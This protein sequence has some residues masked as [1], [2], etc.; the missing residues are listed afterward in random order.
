MKIKNK[1]YIR[2]H[3]LFWNFLPVEARHWELRTNVYVRRSIQSCIQETADRRRLCIEGCLPDTGVYL[4]LDIEGCLPDTGVYLRLDIEC[5]L[6]DTLN[7]CIKSCIPKTDVYWR[8]G[9]VGIEGLLPDTAVFLRPGIEGCL[10][11]TRVYSTRQKKRDTLKKLAVFWLLAK[12][13]PLDLSHWFF[14][15]AL[16]YDMQFDP[17]I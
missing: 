6:P 17:K 16:V 13:R 10:S 2:E 12:G 4:R 1:S 3:Y 14:H 11:N 7:L 9:K 5:S 15:T 8:L